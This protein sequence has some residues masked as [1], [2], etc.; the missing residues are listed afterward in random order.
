LEARGKMGPKDSSIRYGVIGGLAQ[1]LIFIFV[2]SVTFAI[3]E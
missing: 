3:K 2:E 1:V